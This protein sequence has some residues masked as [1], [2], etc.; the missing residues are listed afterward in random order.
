VDPGLET[1]LVDEAT[2]GAPLVEQNQGIGFQILQQH[3]GPL[4]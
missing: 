3:R 4:R 2:G 1:K